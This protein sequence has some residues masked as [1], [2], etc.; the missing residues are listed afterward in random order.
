MK[1]SADQRGARAEVREDL[2][3]RVDLRHRQIHADTNDLENGWSILDVRLVQ[4][5]L[6]VLQVAFSQRDLGVH[7]GVNEGRSEDIATALFLRDGLLNGGDEG[8]AH[9]AKYRARQAA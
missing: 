7:R 6:G 8:R 2:R 4:P 5:E 1:A 9:A 3:E